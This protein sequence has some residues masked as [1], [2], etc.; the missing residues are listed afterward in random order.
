LYAAPELGE[1]Q[2][3]YFFVGVV[4]FQVLVE[5]ADSGGNVSPQFGKRDALVGVGICRD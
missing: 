3:H 1:Q 5:I 4:L 2:N